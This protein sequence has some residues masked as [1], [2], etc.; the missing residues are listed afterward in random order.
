MANLK[1]KDYF[2]NGKRAF[3]RFREKGGKER[4]FPVH[5]RLEEMLDEYLERSGSGA[6]F[7]FRPNLAGE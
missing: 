5:H 4:E 2:Q 3:L 6:N 7:N 1:V